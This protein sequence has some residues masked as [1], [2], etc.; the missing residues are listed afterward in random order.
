LVGCH[1]VQESLSRCDFQWHRAIEPFFPSLM[2]HLKGWI[3][4]IYGCIPYGRSTMASQ[5][6]LCRPKSE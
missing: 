5:T 1:I 4:R 2:S 6:N 3:K